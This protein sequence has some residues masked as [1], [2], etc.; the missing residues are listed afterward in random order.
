MSG[1]RG[2]TPLLTLNLALLAAV[3]VSVLT[4]GSSANA[5]SGLATQR[6]YVMVAGENRRADRS[7]AREDTVYI[8]DLQRALVVAVNYRNNRLEP[9]ATR[10]LTQDIERL[11]PRRNEP[12]R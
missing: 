4:D 8:A 12:R 7:G 11:L 9:I 6:R 10:S 1:K 2:V 3:V 5:Q